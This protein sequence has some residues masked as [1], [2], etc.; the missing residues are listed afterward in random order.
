MGPGLTGHAR[1]IWEIGT[2]SLSLGASHYGLTPKMLTQ[3]EAA[4][5]V[6]DEA[7][8][9]PESATAALRGG[10]DRLSFFLRDVMDP[11]MRGFLLS[12]PEFY[13]E[14]VEARKGPTSARTVRARGGRQTGLSVTE[15]A[16]LNS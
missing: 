7:D 14:Y 10:V 4:I 11:L 3:L 13:T 15:D 6:C 5:V 2:R 9:L 8:I 16:A 12:A 1:A